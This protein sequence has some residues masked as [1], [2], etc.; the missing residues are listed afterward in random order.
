[1]ELLEYIFYLGIVFIIFS[2]IWGFF[3][4]LL[5]LITMRQEKGRIEEY[6]LKAGNLY[7]IAC[8][9]ALSLHDPPSD[10]RLSQEA[11]G[12]T[13]L[14]V[15]GLYLLGR[16]KTQRFRMKVSQG[17]MGRMQLQQKKPNVKIETGFMLATLVFY[18]VAVRFEAVAVNDATL[19]FYNSVW[20]IY[21][22]PV[23]GWIIKVIGFFFLLNILFSGMGVLG[24]FVNRLL[25]NEPRNQRNTFGGT[26]SVNEQDDFDDFEIMEE[27]DE[28]SENTKNSS[29]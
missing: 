8:L 18:S 5:N 4:L 3:M 21:H 22:T 13:G 16:L 1:M 25:G 29:E 12:A 15:L 23:I 14:V 27:E 24:G 28:A 20:D 10:I 2:L 11:F 19:W 7:F 9:T 26:T 17:T 6:I